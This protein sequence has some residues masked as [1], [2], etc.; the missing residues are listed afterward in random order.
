MDNE[1]TAWNVFLNLGDRNSCGVDYVLYSCG[2]STVLQH[3]PTQLQD[4]ALDINH[5]IR[6][7][8]NLQVC[9][10]QYYFW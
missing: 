9:S 7:T 1:E 8:N 5:V 2:D 3:N 4:N 6:E 10:I